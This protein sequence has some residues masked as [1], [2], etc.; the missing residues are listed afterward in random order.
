MS[1]NTAARELGGLLIGQRLMAEG[2]FEQMLT[3]AQEAGLHPVRSL[4]QEGRV[5][6][7]Q[8]LRVAAQSLGLEFCDPGPGFLF[9]PEVLAL[10]DPATALSQLA[11][12]VR[13]DGADGIVIALSDPLNRK[14]VEALER[15]TG[16]RVVPALAPRQALTEALAIAYGSSAPGVAAAGQQHGGDFADGDPGY[17]AN[18]LL[19]AVID[20][21]ASDLHLTAGLPPLMRVHGEI[22]PIPGYRRLLPGQVRTLVFNILS[23]SQRELLEEHRE[24]DCSHPVAGR[25]R[26]RVNVY[27]QRGSVGAAL[28]VIP[29][30]IMSPEELGMPAAVSEFAYLP[31]GLVL[32]TGATGS[33]KS[34]T[35]ASMIDLVN[36]TRAL[37]IMTVEDPIEYMH[38]HK[39][40][41]VNQREVGSDTLGFASALKHALRQDPDVILVGELRDLETMATALT[42]SETGHLVF[43][44]LHTQDAPG[45]VE[46]L[47]DVFPHQQQQQVRVQLAATLQGVISQQL[48]PTVDGRGR[49]AAVEVLV[50]TAAVRNLIREGKVHQIRSAMQAGGKYGMQTMEQS[51]ARLVKAGR[52]SL[53]VATERSSN[54]HELMDLLGGGK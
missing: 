26:F 50:V 14:K 23:S 27:F 46:R 10:L 18:Q 41:I 37:H 48:L 44:T 52:V 20:S 12:P 33:G 21:G 53:A 38:T 51:L 35:L 1:G 30:E 25:G 43:S 39:K 16:G 47:I 5:D 7:Q 3:A 28:R 2:D 32:V 9:D 34:T 49:V 11:L 42:A 31:R 29:M 45:T 17:H 13:L 40:S 54:P 8:V 22:L 24:L 19:E 15:L 4:I 6:S 36:R